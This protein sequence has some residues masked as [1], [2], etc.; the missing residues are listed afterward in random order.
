MIETLLVVVVK[1]R[2]GEAEKRCFSK[3]AI[4]VLSPLRMLE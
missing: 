4:E 2:L 3:E 1:E